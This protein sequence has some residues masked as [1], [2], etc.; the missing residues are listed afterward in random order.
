MVVTANNPFNIIESV[1]WSIDAF[2]EQGNFVNSYYG[3][4]ASET[5]EMMV[6]YNGTIDKPAEPHYE[7]ELSMKKYINQNYYTEIIHTLSV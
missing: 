2:D 7:L 6:I 1:S 5:N 4:L 3:T